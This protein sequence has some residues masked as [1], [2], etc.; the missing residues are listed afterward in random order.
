MT[1]RR[2]LGPVL[3]VAGGVVILA[4]VIAGFV[5]VGG[6]GDARARRLDENKINQMRQIAYAAQCAY[7]AKGE[8]PV[9]LPA[10]RIAL[11]ARDPTPPPGCEYVQTEALTTRVVTYSAPAGDTIELCAD[12]QR[13]PERVAPATN[14]GVFAFPELDRKWKPGR[15]CYSVKLVRIDAFGQ[16]QR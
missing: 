6:P 4:A 16:P 2:D 5:A 9:S 1:S 3:A 15:E 7:T 12:F 14:F 13:P 8:I 11:D 10:I